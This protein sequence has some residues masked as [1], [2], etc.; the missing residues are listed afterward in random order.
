MPREFLSANA[1]SVDVHIQ[2][3]QSMHVGKRPTLQSLSHREEVDVTAQTPAAYGSTIV[4]E[5]PRNS[6]YIG[7]VQLLF[8][9][10]ALAS[11][12]AGANYPRWSDGL[13]YLLIDQVRVSHGSNH[14]QTLT[15]LDIAKIHQMTRSSDD[16]YEDLTRSNLQSNV[17]Q[18]AANAAAAHEVIVPLPLF[19]TAQPRTYLPNHSKVVRQDLR[20]EVTLKALTQLAETDGSDLTGTPSSVVLRV[21][22]IH[23]GATEQA[24]VQQEQNGKNASLSVPGYARMVTTYERQDNIAVAAVTT[25]QTFA[26]NQLRH[27]TKAIQFTVRD[28]ADVPSGLTATRDEFNY[29][30]LASWSMDAQGRTLV[31]PR[32]HL[33]SLFYYNNRFYSADPSKNIYAASWSFNPQATADQFGYLNFNSISQ[34]TLK[35]TMPASWAVAGRLDQMSVVFNIYV[36]TAAGELRMLFA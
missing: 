12:G 35:I 7:Q 1:D 27:P 34:P 20:I 33:Y 25:E 30:Q 11:T 2:G 22:Q 32:T 3:Q 36:L 17:A 18:R 23:V 9:L 21:E 28:N 31:I 29:Q 24:Q 4:Y 14:L 8:Q 15:G 26:L 16:N 13:G 6:D 5:I 10:G 19:W